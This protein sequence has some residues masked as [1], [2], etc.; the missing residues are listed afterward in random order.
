[1]RQDK[2]TTKFQEALGDA[3]SLALG[4]DNAYIE[5]V[6]LL[7]AM[8]R[9]DGDA[10]VVRQEQRVTVGRRGLQRLGRDLAAGP[11]AVLD[12]HRGAQLVLE[13]FAEG[14]CNGVAAGTGRETHQQPDRRA[15]LRLR[16]ARD[17]QG[18]YNKA[19]RQRPAYRLNTLR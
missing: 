19:E 13:L 10:V 17:A 12:H 4:N 6:H 1:M 9:Q 15:A 3:Q 14:A 7:A 18:R 11:G 5:P 16:K 2:L 8:L